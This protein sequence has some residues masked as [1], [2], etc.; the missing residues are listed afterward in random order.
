MVPSNVSKTSLIILITVQILSLN[1][2][3]A[4]LVPGVKMTTIEVCRPL[5][6][7][8]LLTAYC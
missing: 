3:E 2:V 6:G 8:S 5:P 1:V 4:G 7:P